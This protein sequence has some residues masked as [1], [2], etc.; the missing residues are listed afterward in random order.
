[1]SASVLAMAASSGAA[2]W[3]VA[4]LSMRRMS[5]TSSLSSGPMQ[6]AICTA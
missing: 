6:G 2:P 1:V 3:K 4:L 5:F